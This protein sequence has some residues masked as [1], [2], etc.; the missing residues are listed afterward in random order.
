MKKYLPEDP[1]AYLPMVPI[2]EGTSLFLFDAN[3]PTVTFFMAPKMSQI[4]HA[5]LAT[6]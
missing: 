1:L 4:L 2:W 6:F 5:I 3:F